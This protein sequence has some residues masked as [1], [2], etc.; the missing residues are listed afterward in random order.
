M[1][2]QFSRE[3]A[4]ANAF[5]LDPSARDENIDVLTAN[6]RDRHILNAD[7]QAAMSCAGTLQQRKLALFESSIPSPQLSLNAYSE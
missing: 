2:A 5:W 7:V 6:D 3:E 1:Q 4:E